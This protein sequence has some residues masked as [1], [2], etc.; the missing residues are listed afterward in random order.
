MTEIVELS[1]FLTFDYKQLYP[2]NWF[3]DLF[4]HPSVPIIVAIVYFFGSKTFCDILIKLFNIDPKGKSLKNFVTLHSFLLAVYSLWTFVNCSQIVYRHYL[5]TGSIYETLCS[6]K[7]E[8]WNGSYNMSFWI[9]HFYISKYYEFIDTWIVLFKQR[10]PIFL[11]TYHHA[12]IVIVMWLLCVTHCTPVV[13]VV[14]FNSFIHTL[15]YTYYTLASFGYSSPLKHYLTQMQIT[16]FIVGI[17]T[18]VPIHFMT[19]KNNKPRLTNAQGFALWATEI[20][21]FLL[22]FLFAQFYIGTYTKK[23]KKGDKKEE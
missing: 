3:Y 21:A 16:Q 13:V 14:V 18:T 12:G 23:G 11:Q 19:D 8:F 22:I 10:V 1:D 7:D 6:S 15:M 4:A 5:T 9:T 2:N 20:Y 17:S